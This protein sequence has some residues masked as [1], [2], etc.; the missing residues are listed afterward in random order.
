MVAQKDL[1]NE[2]ETWTFKHK[3]CIND[4]KCTRFNTKPIMC[5]AFWG[6]TP[7]WL[8][9]S[10]VT[11]NIRSERNNSFCT[12]TSAHIYIL[13]RLQVE[14]FIIQSLIAS[15]PLLAYFEVLGTSSIHLQFVSAW[16]QIELEL[17]VKVCLE[18]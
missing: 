10:K 5:D 9:T 12:A 2:W 11:L 4:S 1:Q 8:M 13:Y 14:W 17:E 18:V 16:R 3:N 6:L 7:Y 15:I